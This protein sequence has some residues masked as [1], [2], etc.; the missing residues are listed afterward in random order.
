M[1]GCHNVGVFILCAKGQ[2]MRLRTPWGD[3]PPPQDKDVKTQR[4]YLTN[5]IETLIDDY[6]GKRDS[7]RS[8]S[9]FIKAGV[10][11]L[12]G[13]TTILLG[14]RE[15]TAFKP[16]HEWLGIVTL[17]MSGITT[18]FTAW[19][20]FSNTGWRWSHYR[21]MLSRFMILRDEFKFQSYDKSDEEIAAICAK[22]FQDIKDL[23]H[24][25]NRNWEDK[26]FSVGKGR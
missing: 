16:L 3:G 4:D 18:M 2:I 1:F 10:I 14:L 23:L 5:L 19:E 15:F 12:G 11:I 26:R 13:A 6:K 7:A 17:L 24:E 8:A 21:N 20:G 22:T 9:Y 25:A